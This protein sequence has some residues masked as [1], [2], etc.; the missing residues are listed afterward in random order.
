MIQRI[1]TQGSGKT[2]EY[3]MIQRIRMYRI[4]IQGDKFP[5]DRD[6]EK[7]IQRIKI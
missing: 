4:G 1:G 2:E 3:I 7:R 6:P 5:E